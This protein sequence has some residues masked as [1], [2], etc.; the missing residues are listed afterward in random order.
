MT[1]STSR[2]V[3]SEVVLGTAQLRNAYGVM[4]RSGN[5][6]SDID[7]RAMLTTAVAL[8]FD[9]LDTAPAYGEAEQTIGEAML[10]IAVHTKIEPNIDPGT[11]LAE[12]LARLR[13]DRVDVLYMHESTAVLDNAVLEAAHRLVGP[14]VGI[15]GASVYDIAEFDAAVA[16]PRI[17]AVQVPLNLFDRRFDGQR[18]SSA[19]ENDVRV[20]A[21][22]ALLQGVLAAAPAS[23]TG[24]VAGLRS[25]VEEFD[26]AA[27]CLGRSRVELA[28][29]WVRSFAGI[30][31]VVVGAESVEEME[32]LMRALR[33]A[34]LTTAEVSKLGS[35]AV[36]PLALTDPRRW[37]KSTD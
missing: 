27:K 10:S 25:Y 26:R 28:L 17:G 37:E 20:Y 16:D 11:S 2:H 35:L 1:E 19:T 34:P 6:R 33:A 14:R 21:R 7:A 9:A 18:L 32:G 5:A 22:S 15:L 24:P 4:R 30:R 29:G 3:D 13:R 12:S 23:V 8:G 31:G 36:P